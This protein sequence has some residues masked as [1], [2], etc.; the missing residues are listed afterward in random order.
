MTAGAPGRRILVVGG[1][2]GIGGAVVD[3]LA[4][5]GDRIACA[6]LDAEAA[7]ARSERHSPHGRTVVPVHLDVT[8]PTSV[9]MAVAAA[10]DALGGLD[11][12]VYAAGVTTTGPATEVTFEQWRRVLA[13]N[14]DG[15]FQVAREVVGRLT[16]GAAVVFIGSQLAASAI[17]DKA[18]YIASKGGLEALTRALAVEW[19][20]RGVRVVCLAPG[21]VRGGMLLERIGADPAA[22]GQVEGRIPL[23]RLGEPTEIAGAVRFLLGPDAGF[24]TGEIL[25]ADGGYR[26]R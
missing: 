12:L 15:A 20:P 4:E 13:V 14:L 7:S 6:D 21:P 9:E 25:V 3:R 19:A 16:R 8:D 1:A 18:A 23:G 5:E 11:G 24:I 2:H 17:P 22:L 26:A 10:D